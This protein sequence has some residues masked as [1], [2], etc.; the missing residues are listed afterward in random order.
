M[1]SCQMMSKLSPP[2]STVRS[3]FF[4]LPRKKDLSYTK[5][6]LFWFKPTEVLNYQKEPSTHQIRQTH[7]LFTKLSTKLMMKF[8]TSCT[9]ARLSPIFQDKK[10][11]SWLELKTKISLRSNW[12]RTIMKLSKLSKA[13]L[14]ESDAL[15]SLRM[16]LL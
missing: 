16:L 8:Q 2:Q 5:L 14:W 6:F 12:K 3:A 11:L 9:L 10:T 15:I 4:Q 7:K 13:T 1:I